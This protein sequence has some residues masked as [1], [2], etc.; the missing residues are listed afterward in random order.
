MKESKYNFYLQD[1]TGMVI[2]LSVHFITTHIC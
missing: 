2:S 1:A